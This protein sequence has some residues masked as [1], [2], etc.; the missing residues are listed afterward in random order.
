MGSASYFPVIVVGAGQA[1]LSAS[2]WLKQHNIEHLVLEKNQLGHAWREERWD[3][4]CLVT[5]NWQCQL[6]GFP[7]TGEEPHG[8]MPKHLI[9]RYLESYADFLRPPLRTGVSVERIRPGDRGG[10][11][12][13]TSQGTFL[14][15]HVIL[16]VGAY[17][18]PVVPPFA[19][20]LDPSIT[21]LHSRDY[22][23]P[24]QLPSG[25]VLV[26]GS[27]Q[28]GCQI[29]EDLH[30]AGRNV[31]LCLGDAPRSPRV[32]RG[33]DVVAW[34]DEMG[35]YDTPVESHPD[36]DSTRDKTNHYLTGRDGGREI[37]LRKLA[38]EGMQLYG[39]L[40]NLSAR[41]AHFK[42]DLAQRL[43]GADQV[44]VGIRKLIDGYIERTG[45]AAPEEP[46]YVPVWQ[47]DTAPE[48]LDF[49]AKDV[50]SIVWCIG[51]RSDF[52]FVEVPI[53]D[54]R[55]YPRHQRGVSEAQGLYF[56]G[57]PWLHTWGSGRMS[58]VGRDAEYV[59][60]HLAK[61]L[62]AE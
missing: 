27:G 2:Y 31:H 45:R 46:A 26:V 55:G 10:Y 36:V 24:E 5:P 9:V 1:G 21:Q 25:A 48:Y 18:T 11:V 44:Y 15:K 38:L 32:Y 53:F 56:L 12:L 37:D 8:F 6:P 43:D 16:T 13:D 51:F 19:R 40:A 58:G 35:Y 54:D 20:H 7:Y 28:S 3:T 41:A 23:N 50:R 49:A 14:A 22:K 47:P 29:A 33:K 59:V 57:L 17:H 61:R 42:P 39:Y 30:F 52:R 34:L 62:S 4:F 60:N